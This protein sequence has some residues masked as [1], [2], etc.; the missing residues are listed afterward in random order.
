MQV[1][2]VVHTPTLSGTGT[3][4]ARQTYMKILAGQNNNQAGASRLMA[5]ANGSPFIYRFA[6][7][8]KRKW[9]AR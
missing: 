1:R 7:G 3:P 9:S 6:V 5:N 2:T 8:Y 4:E